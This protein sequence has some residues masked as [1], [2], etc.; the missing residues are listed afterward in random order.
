MITKKTV[1]VL[2]AGA[3]KPYGLPL[4][5]E[6]AEKLV[7]QTNYD[8]TGN[9]ECLEIL[10]NA[11]GNSLNEENTLT[12]FRS[13]YSKAKAESIDAFL[14]SR[15]HYIPCAKHAIA[16]ILLKHEREDALFAMDNKGDWYKLLIRMLGAPYARFHENQIAIITYN[17]DRS[18]EHTLYNSFSTRESDKVSKDEWIAKLKECVPTIHLHG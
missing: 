18:L 12:E 14:E 3:S 17:Y 15:Q 6:L 10:G 11:S 13:E 4:G 16:W 2:G 1:F 5:E 7:R 8:D 9:K